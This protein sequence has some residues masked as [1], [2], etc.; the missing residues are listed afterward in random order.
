MSDHFLDDDDI[1]E[2]LKAVQ[3]GEGVDPQGPG[4]FRHQR[5]VRRHD[6]GKPSKLA[7]DRQRQLHRLHELLCR[8]VSMRASAHLRALCE[9]TFLGIEQ[10]TWIE[11]TEALPEGTIAS[12]VSVAPLGERLMVCFEHQLALAATSRLLGSATSD[13]WKVRRAELTDI[14]F[15]L[16]GYFL[17]HVLE[18]LEGVWSSVA[19]LKFEAAALRPL[20]T[21]AHIVPPRDAAVAVTFEVRLDQTSS[22]MAILYPYRTIEPVVDRLTRSM[23]VE[24][25]EQGE[26][27]I[28]SGLS[29]VP[30]VV[31]AELDRLEMSV[32]EISKLKVGDVLTFQRPVSDGVTVYIE[33][34]QVYAGEPGRAEGRRVV[35]VTRRVDGGSA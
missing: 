31:R 34:E 15:Q 18:E 35:R 14:E 17:N 27:R 13:P 19:P 6:F 30:V 1:Q 16:A 26:E 2:L 20:Q 8:K 12:A 9:V 3:S 5:R 32:R 4:S 23:D 29:N 22:V 25:D 24:A 7:P 10:S 33:G 28:R 21:Q 11:A